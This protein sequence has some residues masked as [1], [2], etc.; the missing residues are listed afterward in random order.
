MIEG[1][2]LCLCFP[3]VLSSP[4]AIIFLSHPNVADHKYIINGD[5]TINKH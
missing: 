3:D 4:A 5:S 2:S 1:G